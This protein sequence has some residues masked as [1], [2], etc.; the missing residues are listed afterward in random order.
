MKL[1]SPLHFALATSAALALLGLGRNDGEAVTRPVTPVA[2][3]HG[4][5]D[6]AGSV[7]SANADFEDFAKP[8]LAAYCTRCHGERR[9]RG[10]LR[11]DD[12]PRDMRDATTSQLW[13]NIYAQ[14]RFGQM[15]PSDSSRQPTD[16]EREAFTDWI[17]SEQSRY[18]RG[19]ALDEKLLLPEYGNYVNHAKL[20]SGENQEAP[21]TPARLW[22]MRPSIYR[23]LWEKAYGRSHRLSVK[24][25][26][27]GGQD[28]LHTVQ[29]GAHRGKGITTRYF[30]DPRY[31]NPFYEFVHH[32]SGFTDYATITADAASLEALLV[33]AE[34]MAEILTLGVPTSV[35]TEVKNK[36]SKHGNNHG[37]FVGGVQTNTVERR[38]EVPAAFRRVMQAQGALSEKDFDEA[39]RVA[40]E[41]LLRRPP[42]ADEK[43]HYRADVFEPN[44]ELG[45]T[46]ALQAV[47]IFITLS[48]EFVYRMELGL[49]ERDEHG[50][51]M[52]SP[53]ELVYAIHHAFHDTPPFG[54]A[55]HERVDVYEK[56][57]EEII[58]RDLTGRHRWSDRADSWLVKEMESDQLVTR[59]DVERAVRRMLDAPPRNLH[60][61]HNSPIESTRNPRVLRFFREYFGYHRAPSVFKDVDEFKSRT[62]FAQFNSHTPHRLKYDTDAL[63][64]HI[65]E[66]DQDV[67]AELLT[68]NQS[69]VSYWDGT[70]PPDR[71]KKAGGKERYAETHDAQSYNLDPFE[72]PSARHTPIELP[73]EQRC[74]ILTQPSWLVAHSG[75]FDNDP[76][77][78]GKWIREKLLAS[79]VLDLPVTVDAR[80][81]DDETKTL[82]ERFSVVEETECWRCHKRMNPL[83]TPFEAYN[84]VGRFR[85]EEL[86]RP[87]DTSGAIDYTGD[88]EL[89]GP[90]ADARELLERLAHSERVRQSFVRHVFRYWMGRNELLSDSRT[91]IAMD[92][93]YVESEGSF[94]EL[95]V[96]L[97]TSDSF[98]YRK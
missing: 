56:D 46:M 52:L 1:R 16:A 62:D 30:A 43:A 60:P 9:Q 81:P 8:F 3:G 92:R 34:A 94:K 55:E 42:E 45:N 76:V 6:P 5:R 98:L 41:I 18:G 37:M 36:D 21:F 48:P 85:L 17:D 24:I 23:E 70:N 2:D 59:E 35:T 73:V 88:D 80:I 15:P 40:F 66:E 64:L 13:T 33:N 32:A 95:L 53:R 79:F 71:I 69:F 68:T 29:K 4:A 12:P 27:S 93:A 22:R 90:V 89:D 39:L 65:L 26:G 10:E 91:L 49:G 97:L 19:F 50:R 25:G 75:N 20:F 83:G 7:D 74:G 31:A 87:V 57:S 78:R 67:L 86:G 72:N 63:V 11:F 51:R 61:N 38:G 82:R 84:H 44:A 47:L 58:K 96:S 54:V 77:R 14:V 28:A